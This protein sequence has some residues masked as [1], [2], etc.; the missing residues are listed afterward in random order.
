MS[1]EDFFIRKMEGRLVSG[2]VDKKEEKKVIDRKESK[3][4]K[5]GGRRD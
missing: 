5:G 4:E 3:I 2:K 1:Q